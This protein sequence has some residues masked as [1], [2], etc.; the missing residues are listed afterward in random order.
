MHSLESLNFS[1]RRNVLRLIEKLAAIEPGT[2]ATA[3][4][5][6]NM[7]GPHL[8]TGTI[9]TSGAT[10]GYL[11]G[12]QPLDTSGQQRR[13]VAELFSLE[14]SSEPLPG[15]TGTSGSTVD[16]THGD[17]VTAVFDQAP[18]GLFTITGFAVA[19]PAAGVFATGG[20]W[21][22]TSRDRHTP[23]ARLVDIEVVAEAGSHNVP[24]P[25][26]IVRWPEATAPTD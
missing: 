20:G 24:I 11:L 13:P 14:V 19:T 26:P 18:Y 17:I 25:A 9:V 21:F 3:A 10:G 23:A 15:R 2:V 7:Y 8:V 16:P 1:G 6:S 12:G 22:L 4:F 5:R